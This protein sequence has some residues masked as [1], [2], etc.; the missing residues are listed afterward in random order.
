MGAVS[1]EFF[2]DRVFSLGFTGEDLLMNFVFREWSF[3]RR[4]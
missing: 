2:V 3:L 1:R 4:V